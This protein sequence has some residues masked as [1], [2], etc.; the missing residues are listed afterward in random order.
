MGLFWQEDIIGF[1]QKVRFTSSARTPEQCYLE[2]AQMIRTNLIHLNEYFNRLA[3]AME[4]W[5]HLWKQ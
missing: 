4:I 1:F 3:T 2:L 5:I